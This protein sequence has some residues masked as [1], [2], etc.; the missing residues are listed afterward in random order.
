M[1]TPALPDESVR[2]H[3]APRQT[4]AP[5]QSSPR[6][7]DQQATMPAKV[8]AAPPQAE[9]DLHFVHRRHSDQSSPTAGSPSTPFPNSKQTLLT[10]PRASSSRP[11]LQP[12]TTVPC[13]ERCP[14]ARALFSYV[15][16]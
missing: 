4:Q 5:R 15:E 10:V 3:S 13:Y 9:A 6:A 12:P 11:A 7:P 16:E 8:S 2:R 1:S 14:L